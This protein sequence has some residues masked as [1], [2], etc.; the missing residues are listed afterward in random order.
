LAISYRKNHFVS[1]PALASVVA[2]I[3]AADTDPTNAVIILTWKIL[4]FIEKK[5]RAIIFEL[6]FWSSVPTIKEFVSLLFSGGLLIMDT[7]QVE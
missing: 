2:T 1:G 6:L 7:Q 4:S 5:W 3:H